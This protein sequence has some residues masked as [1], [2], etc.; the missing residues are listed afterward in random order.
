[1][2][3]KAS[4]LPNHPIY[5][6]FQST[7]VADCVWSIRWDIGQALRKQKIFRPSCCGALLVKGQFVEWAQSRIY[8]FFGRFTDRKIAR[9][10]FR[11][12]LDM[13]LYWSKRLHF[14]EITLFTA[15][16]WQ[17][18]SGQGLIILLRPKNFPVG[19]QIFWKTTLQSNNTFHELVSV[20][21]TMWLS[22]GI[23]CSTLPSCH[24][25]K[26]EESCWHQKRF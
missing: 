14:R 17:V 6:V 21:V 5:S 23:Q 26:V 19:F 11:G 25:G 22:K 16:C 9:N 1:M 12:L 20:K 18:I 4:L 3:D 7:K 24:A 13:S 2:E 8:V 10:I 15:L